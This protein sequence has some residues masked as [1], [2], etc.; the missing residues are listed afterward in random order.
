MINL[1]RNVLNTTLFLPFFVEIC[2]HY[3]KDYRHASIGADSYSAHEAR[4]KT[5][6]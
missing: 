4:A 6:Q 5:R 1:I 3:T 2:L